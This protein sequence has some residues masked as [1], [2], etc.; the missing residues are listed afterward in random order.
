MVANT[1]GEG[2]IIQSIYHTEFVMLEGGL[3]W[4]GGGGGG[5]SRMPPFWY[6]NNITLYVS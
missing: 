1:T 5:N 3:W 6:Y 2:E 4:G